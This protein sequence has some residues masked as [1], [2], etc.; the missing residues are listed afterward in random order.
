MRFSL[1]LLQTR[2]RGVQRPPVTDK[3]ID[4]KTG[5]KQIENGWSSS[6][7]FIRKGGECEYTCEEMFMTFVKDGRCGIT[8]DKLNKNGSIEVECGSASYYVYE[9]GQTG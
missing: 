3:N 1:T 6:I 5:Y 7:L 4:T 9:F 2:D 8:D